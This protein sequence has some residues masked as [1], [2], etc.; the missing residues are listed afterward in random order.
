MKSRDTLLIALL[1]TLILVVGL[2]PITRAPVIGDDFFVL[3]QS[4]GQ[5]G[6]DFLTW[7]SLAWGWGLQAGHFNPV[8]QVLG[9][10]YHFLALPITSLLGIAPHHYYIAGSYALITLAILSA[11]YATKAMIKYVWH[12]AALPYWRIYGLLAAIAGVTVQIHPWSNDPVTTYSMAGFGSA[13]IAF[14]LV[15]LAFSAVRVERVS[16]LRI[17][18]LSALSVFAVVYYEMLVAAVAAAAV[19]YAGAFIRPRP[20]IPSHRSRAVILLA[21]SVVLPAVV[22]IAGRAYVSLVSGT[23]GYT[24]ASVALGFD[25]A[26]TLAF[27]VA[28]SLPGGA[29]P[30]TLY[31]VDPVEFGRAAIVTSFVLV[32]A[33]IAFALVWSRNPGRSLGMS[34]RVWIPVSALATLWILSTLAHAITPKYIAEVSAPGLVYL[35]Y[36]V[37]MLVVT[38]LIAIAVMA[39]RV[40]SIWRVTSLMLL[41]WFAVGQQAINWT[42]STMQRDAYVVNTDLGS[43]INDPALPIEARCERLQAWIDRGWP[44]YYLDA[45]V[46]YAPKSFE[47]LTGE[48]FCDEDFAENG[49]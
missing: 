26:R 49:R 18:A 35:F 27:G 10:A 36:A 40:P 7:M 37:G 13:A 48:Q 2:L 29:W 17:I 42:L 25:A 21:V 28:S 38:V 1:G 46:E 43:A 34:G 15:G 45:I 3:F 39:T 24:G 44:E 4:Q 22:F 5:S 12:D 20:E 9:G 19:A 14:L 8:G 31:R 47:Q 23:G 16:A 41:I 30:Y 11:A 6:G 33:L 32:L